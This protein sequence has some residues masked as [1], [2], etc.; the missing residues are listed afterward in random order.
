MRCNVGAMA[1]PA[2]TATVVVAMSQKQGRDNFV[3]LTFFKHMYRFLR[4]L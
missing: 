3:M 2:G 1:T 4:A